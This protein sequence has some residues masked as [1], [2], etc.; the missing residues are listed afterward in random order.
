MSL[1]KYSLGAL[2][3]IAGAAASAQNAMDYVD[4]F[5]GTGG[6][7]HTY[8]GAT[9]PFGMVQLS[10]DNG[11]QGW[12]WCSG[13]NY[14]DSMIAGF[15]HM[16]LS[17]T[18]CGDWCDISVM[19]NIEPIPDTAR[20]FRVK[21]EHRFEGS[22][23]GFYHVKLGNDILV[24]LS[25]TEHCGLH[26]YMFP[27]FSKP[28]IKFNLSFGI[29]WDSTT[30]SS[31]RY[32][33]DSTIVGYRFSTGW[34]KVQRVY[35]AARTS[36]HFKKLRTN[37]DEHFVRE[38]GKPGAVMNGQLLFDDLHGL[39]LEMKVGLSTVSTKKALEALNELP[40]WDFMYTMRNAGVSWTREMDRIQ[41]ASLDDKLKRI[42]YS[43]LYHTC[44]A[45]VLYSDQDGEY[46]NAKGKTLKMQKGQRYTVYSLWDTFRG[47]NPLFTITQPERNIDILNSMLAFYDEN[48]L[49]PVW[50]LSSWETNCMS[51]YHAVPVLADAILKETPGLDAAHAYE[52][53]K[54]S[55][56]QNVRGT[57]DYIK[58]GYLPQ[59]K[60]SSSV[61]ITL[62][63]AYDDWCIAQVAKKLGKTD[64]Y[65]LFMKRA[66]AYQLLFDKS[67]GFIR[68]KNTDG[69]WVT[70]FDPF[71]ASTDGKSM[72][73]E[74]NAWQY[75]F[76]VPHDV[77]GLAKEFGSYD[78]FSQKLDSL[79]TVSSV[80]KG[81]SAPPD[82]SGLIGQYAHGNEPSHHIAYMYSY[83][84]DSWKTQ[85]RVRS[86]IDSMYH[87]QPDGYAGNEDCG[88]MSAWAVWSM[89]GFYPVNPASGEYV[90][91]SPVFDQV[92]IPLPDGKT[93]VVKT[94]NNAKDHPYIQSVSLNGFPYDRCYI[95]HQQIMQGGVLQ[96]TMGDKPNKDFG[97]D[98]NSWPSSMSE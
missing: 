12:D 72:Y 92:K 58:Y 43:G 22:K 87:D 98:K 3:C 34:A 2:L 44:M 28:A 81:E 86:I 64:D 14:G 4:P 74:G 54:A 80:V 83:V 23:P 77:R 51:G 10:P 45:P 6:H 41:V 9:V 95:T 76:F 60:G 57:Q 42:F 36:V 73:E 7:G 79:F 21:F 53:M 32:V 31:I 46:T 38:D 56:F 63:Y 39:P 20:N 1:K 70:P 24:M 94:L 30:A 29:N 97:K 19:P 8:P 75:T 16:H 84:G 68:G 17:G 35:F 27:P 85:A 15:S 82:V 11:T 88:Q 96:F 48:G 91:G 65:K 59:D 61:T 50:D 69:S 52:A 13:Y 78:K 55:A 18:G 67:T 90:F 5:I 49:L 66:A 93:F 71:E 40:N 62:E 37:V 26:R 89:M 25:A 33:D 47:L